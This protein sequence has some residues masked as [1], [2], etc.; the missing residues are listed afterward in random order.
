MNLEKSMDSLHALRKSSM[1][2][3]D[4]TYIRPG[5]IYNLNQL[6]PYTDNLENKDLPT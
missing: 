4:F 2:Q 5:D 3:E 1:K 6:E